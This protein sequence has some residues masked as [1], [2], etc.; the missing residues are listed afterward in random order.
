MSVEEGLPS[1]PTS[2]DVYIAPMG[3]MAVRH[4]L[5]LAA[6]IRQT[7]AS[8]ELGTDR[9]L[10]RMM[11]LANR[12]NARYTLIVGDSEIVTKSYSLKDMSS[13]EQT[14]LTRQALIERL[15]EASQPVEVGR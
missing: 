8:V 10:K 11:E 14:T 1:T 12:L 9:K 15:R 2:L 4:C 3:D 6:E 13:G 5:S 7:G